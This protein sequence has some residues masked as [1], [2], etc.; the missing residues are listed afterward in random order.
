MDPGQIVQLIVEEEHKPEPGL[1]LTQLQLMVVLSVL[2]RRLKLRTA[3]NI[4]VQVYLYF[5][6]L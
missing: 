4:I 5:F 2:V 6:H 3:T 1:V